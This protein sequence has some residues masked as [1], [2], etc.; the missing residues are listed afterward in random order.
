MSPRI[1][2]LFLIYEATIDRITVSFRAGGDAPGSLSGRLQVDQY[3]CKHL[4]RICGDFGG[5]LSQPCLGSSC[6]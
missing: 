2:P 6:E 1:D 5:E 4:P 3:L